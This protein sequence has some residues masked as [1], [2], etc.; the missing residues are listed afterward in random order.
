MRC[1]AESVVIAEDAE[2]EPSERN[3]TAR[4]T[5]TPM[6]RDLA[7]ARPA[8]DVANI[9]NNRPPDRACFHRRALSC[10]SMYIGHSSWRRRTS[11][12][13]SCSFVRP[14]KHVAR[15]ECKNDQYY[16]GPFQRQY[17]ATVKCNLVCPL[18][19]E[20]VCGGACTGLVAAMTVYQPIV[21]TGMILKP[22]Y[23]INLGY[24]GFFYSQAWPSLLTISNFYREYPAGG[25][26]GSRC[27]TLCSV[28]S[29]AFRTAAVSDG[30][31][32][33][34]GLAIDM[35]LRAG[36]RECSR[37]VTSNNGEICGGQSIANTNLV[38]AYTKRP[39]A[40]T[41]TPANHFTS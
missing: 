32:Y 6:I 3:A 24:I 29:T 12:Q 28:K 15:R 30:T 21:S 5:H 34:S 31:C 36:D 8:S 35:F 26:D 13:P 11:D 18:N 14:V 17:M 2:R 27:F 40:P 25:T 9:T 33:C 20:Q 41:G 38:V 37:P 1:R 22:V 39:V 10:M 4:V 19:L 16:R 7:L 23:L